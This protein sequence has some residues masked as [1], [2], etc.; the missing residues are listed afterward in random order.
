[1]EEKLKLYRAEKEF[2]G[3]TIRYVN[4]SVIL[5]K[6]FLDSLRLINELN[7][8]ERDSWKKCYQTYLN[9]RERFFIVPV[10]FVERIIITIKKNVQSIIELKKRR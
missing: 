7:K 9:F 8:N 2:F 6:G 5:A 10:V 4:F 3:K 1:M